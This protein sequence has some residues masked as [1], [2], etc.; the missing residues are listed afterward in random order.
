VSAFLGR[1]ARNP[2]TTWRRLESRASR[3]ICEA[4]G[5]EVLDYASKTQAH[6]GPSESPTG[7]GACQSSAALAAPRLCN[8][9]WCSLVFIRGLKV[10]KQGSDNLEC[11][12]DIAR[13]RYPF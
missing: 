1:A 3:D 11:A 7:L 4:R 2:N 13:K 5:V 12:D 6:H 9:Y 10:A 8:D